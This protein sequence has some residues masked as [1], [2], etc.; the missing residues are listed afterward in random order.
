MGIAQSV[1]CSVEIATVQLDIARLR[2]DVTTSPAQDVLSPV[3]VKVVSWT[4][5]GVDLISVS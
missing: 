2:Q 4:L 5:Y 3:E 1:K